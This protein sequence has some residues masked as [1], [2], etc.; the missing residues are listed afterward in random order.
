LADVAF[1]ATLPFPCCFAE[2]PEAA[3]FD[4]EE[5]DD[6]EPCVED[7]PVPDVEDGLC[8]DDCDCVDCLEVSSAP[9]AASGAARVATATATAAGAMYFSCVVFMRVMVF[10]FGN[11][12]WVVPS[13]HA[14]TLITPQHPCLA[15]SRDI[16]AQRGSAKP[17]L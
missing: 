9:I 3:L 17:R 15:A 8:V 5:P 7:E 1:F 14:W 11:D 2:L 16:A 12:G 6:W 13:A 4:D 10:P